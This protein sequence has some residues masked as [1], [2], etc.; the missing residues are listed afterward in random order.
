MVVPLLAAAQPVGALVLLD[1][2]RDFTQRQATLVQVIAAQAAE[3]IAH[4]PAPPPASG[5]C[6][7]GVSPAQPRGAGV[8]PASPDDFVDLQHLLDRDA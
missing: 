7:A 4:L 2:R 8:S 1:P 3:M 6:G 5:P